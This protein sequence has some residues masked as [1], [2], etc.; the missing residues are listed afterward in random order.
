MTVERT[1]PERINIALQ[2]RCWRGG[3]NSVDFRPRFL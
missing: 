1:S 3:D 2:G